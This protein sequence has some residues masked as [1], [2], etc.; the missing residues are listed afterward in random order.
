MLAT[1]KEYLLSLI[2]YAIKT[3]L[4]IKYIPLQEFTKTFIVKISIMCKIH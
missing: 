2:L 3:D 1:P 4:S